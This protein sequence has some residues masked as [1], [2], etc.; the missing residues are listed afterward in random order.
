MQSIYNYIVKLPVKMEIIGP[1]FAPL[2]KKNNR[3]RMHVIIKTTCVEDS[4]EMMRNLRDNLKNISIK[5]S[6]RIT[7]DIDP[8]NVL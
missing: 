3:Y 1:S 8:E 5:K 2:S 7:I 4:Q 6:S